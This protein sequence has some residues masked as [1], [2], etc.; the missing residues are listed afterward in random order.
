MCAFS[1]YIKS[2]ISFSMY[3]FHCSLRMVNVISS[4]HVAA[5]AKEGEFEKVAIAYLT[6]FYYGHVTGFRRVR[7]IPKSAHYFLQVCPSDRTNQRGPQKADF[8]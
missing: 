7:K 2:K 6:V 1:W 3:I 4:K 5:Y 8:L